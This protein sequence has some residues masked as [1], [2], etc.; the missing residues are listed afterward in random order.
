MAKIMIVDDSAYARRVHRSMLEKAGYSVIEAA[1]GIGAIEM[2]SLE[3]PDAVILDLSMADLGGLDVLK[4]LR[5]LDDQCHVIVLS[6]DVQ[7]TT[8]QSVLAAGA[9]RFL[10]KPANAE[11]LS[12]AVSNV[13]G[14][15]RA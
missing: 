10:A 5:E 14:V 11:Q 13:L 9:K 12:A 4:T 3:H 7:R 2:F 1:T 15:S 6:A 8:E